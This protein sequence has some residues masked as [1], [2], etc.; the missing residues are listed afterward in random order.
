MPYFASKF[1]AGHDM[2]PIFA[3]L[4]R[5]KSPLEELKLVTRELGHIGGNGEKRK[6]LGCQFVDEVLNFIVQTAKHQVV[7]VQ[8][9]EKTPI[10]FS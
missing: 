6:K 4:K 9:D 10:P 5:F 8:Q 3:D 1:S 2:D 7:H